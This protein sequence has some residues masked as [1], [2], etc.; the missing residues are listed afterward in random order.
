M[1]LRARLFALVA[2]VVAISV[3]LATITIS[4]AARRSF[5]EVDRQRTR[6]VLTQ[7]RRE[8]ALQAEDVAR[9]RAT[10][11]LIG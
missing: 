4:A 11:S 1:T 3:T 5:E 9:T 10:A 7:F 2:L 6:A 8:F